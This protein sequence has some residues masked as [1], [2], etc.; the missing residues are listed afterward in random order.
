LEAAKLI[1]QAANQQEALQR[2]RKWKARW[3]KIAPCAVRCLERDLEELFSIFHPA[4]EYA[5]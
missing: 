5:D 2:F 3:E 1:Y 4:Q